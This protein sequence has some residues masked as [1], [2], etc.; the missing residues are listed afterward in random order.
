MVDAG[1]DEM[2]ALTLDG[3][4]YGSD[5]KAWGGEVLWADLDGFERIAHLQEIPL[6]GGEMAVKDPRRLVFA[7]SELLGRETSLFDEREAE[8]L[9]KTM[10]KSTRTTSFGRVLDAL[11]CEFDICRKRTYDG[12]P[13]MKLEQH[14]ERG[15]RSSDLRAEVRGD[16]IMTVP[17]YGDMLSMTGTADD[18]ASSFTYALLKAL[19]DKAV[20]EAH[21]R[22]L[23]RIG[24]TGGVSVNRT[25]AS[26][27]EEL[28]RPRGLELVCHDRVPNGD[29]GVSTGQCAIALKSTS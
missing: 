13:A 21:N 18:R 6:L 16:E 25:I 23:D 22:G 8:V 28:V 5:G 9:R 20:D 3:T 2:V 7:I 11:A 14:L 24:L 1:Q 12:E 29:G 19:V 17:L 27:T 10:K 26:M 4:G 15:S